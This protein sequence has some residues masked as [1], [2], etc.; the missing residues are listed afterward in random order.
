MNNYKNNHTPKIKMKQLVLKKY[1]H[2]CHCKQ[3]QIIKTDF[4]PWYHCAA[5]ENSPS[6]VL[7]MEVHCRDSVSWPFSDSTF[8]TFIIFLYGLLMQDF[9]WQGEFIHILNIDV[10]ERHLLICCLQNRWHHILSTIN[11]MRRKGIFKA[12]SIHKPAKLKLV[13]NPII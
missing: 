1:E 8:F 4:L 11:T 2:V 6:H 3:Y 9:Y 5:C 12:G 7:P 13:L 10:H